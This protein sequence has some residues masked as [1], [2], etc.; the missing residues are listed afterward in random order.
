MNTDQLKYEPL[1]VVRP[2]SLH[3]HHELTLR[4]DNNGIAGWRQSLRLDTWLEAPR[5]FLVWQFPTIRIPLRA[6]V[7]MHSETRSDFVVPYVGALDKVE[8]RDLSTMNPSKWISVMYVL[9]R[10]CPATLVVFNL[11][12]RI[13]L[14]CGGGR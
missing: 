1:C 12:G 5:Q 13:S 7:H 2:A 8:H 14:A 11:G 9:I 6:H 4:L 10:R 3:D